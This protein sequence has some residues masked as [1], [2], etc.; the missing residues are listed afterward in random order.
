MK[1]KM[2]GSL[3]LLIQVVVLAG[4]SLMQGCT[5]GDAP[6]RWLNWP[7]NT[8]R[9]V[10]AVLPAGP[11]ITDT[12]IL[13]VDSSMP[14]VS[15]AVP[16]A[17]VHTVQKGETL[18]S[19]ASS[20]GTSWK[21]LADYNN[22]SNPNVVNVGQEIRIPE[23][24]NASA[25]VKRT[26]S[27]VSSRP[28]PSSIKQGTS[29]TIQKGDALST[30]AKRSGL[31]I[32]EIKMANGMK[33]DSL[34][35]GKKLTI[36]KKGEVKAV[37]VA[38]PIPAKAANPVSAKAAEVT[39]AS[40]P[41]PAPIAESVPAATAPEVA[42]V[43]TASEAAPAAH[44]SSAPVYEHV[45]YPGETLDDVA[46]QYGSSQQEI[47]KLNNITDPSSVKP[48]TKLLVPIPE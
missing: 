24:L 7:Y 27:P 31:T 25:P 3:V 42:P 5:T 32:N 36:P 1:A 11:D 33:S 6:V 40:L 9:D 26:S 23:S 41:P 14:I 19:I 18:S 38:K 28:V 8:P 10:P 17:K 13:P 34:V 39:D 2:V 29:Y 47:M 43:V 46:R 4:F 35:A 12:G 20:Y 21:A 16:S 48:G 15:S 44:A 30:I 37:A 22:L 45:L